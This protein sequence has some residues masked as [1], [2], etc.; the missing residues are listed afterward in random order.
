M[1]STSVGK[2]VCLYSRGFVAFGTEPYSFSLISLLHLTN[3]LVNPLV[4]GKSTC[5]RDVW[6][7]FS[8]W[9][10][11]SKFG[12]LWSVVCLVEGPSIAS[13]NEQPYFAPKENLP[14][15]LGT[16]EIWLLKLSWLALSL[17]LQS[18]ASCTFSRM[19]KSRFSFSSGFLLLNMRSDCKKINKT[20]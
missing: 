8:V 14:L 12:K 3:P 6:L 7:H 2:M 13:F 20:E 16:T 19:K 4:E 9:S 15:V 5:W 18:C 17:S 1:C 11:R 10:S